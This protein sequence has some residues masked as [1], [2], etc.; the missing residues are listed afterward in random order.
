MIY[1]KY[2]IAN[3]RPVAAGLPPAIYITWLFQFYFL[4][5]AIN[6][7]PNAL[8]FG[9]YTHK[10]I[11][12]MQ[13]LAQQFTALLVGIAAIVRWAHAH[14]NANLRTYRHRLIAVNYLVHH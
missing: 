5:R 3:D 14:G 9:A 13:N 6:P 2:K 8:C 11:L 12:L 1:G 4:H 10:S 7:F